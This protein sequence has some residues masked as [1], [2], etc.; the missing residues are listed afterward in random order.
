MY[1]AVKRYFSDIW[2]VLEDIPEY[3]WDAIRARDEYHWVELKY[4][5]HKLIGNITSPLYC[6]RRGIKNLYR[7]FPIIWGDRDFDQG[8]LLTVMEKK[9]QF[10]EEFFKSDKAWCAGAKRT[11]KQI[12]YAR[13]LLKYQDDYPTPYRDAFYKKFG[14]DNFFRDS[15]P[16]KFDSLGKPMLFRCVDNQSDEYKAAYRE[17]INK[18]YEFEKK[19]DSHLWKF[20]NKR[21][22]GWWD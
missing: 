12:A 15:V 16:V 8:Y 21:I 20:I 9:L 13:K 14:E 5:W 2:Y 11:A 1:K 19:I 17:A 22:R 10:M 3:T 6:L 7:W 4:K 18:D